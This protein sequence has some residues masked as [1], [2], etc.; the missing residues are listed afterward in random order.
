M[1]LAVVALVC[2]LA[3]PPIA[4]APVTSPRPGTTGADR[5]RAAVVG[6]DEIDEDA[7]ARAEYL[8]AIRG[9]WEGHLDGGA[10]T[11]KLARAL[12]EFAAGEGL[13]LPAREDQ[14]P[15][16]VFD[17]L[18]C[19]REV[20]LGWGGDGPRAP[21]LSP[22][23]IWRLEHA[24]V[25]RGFLHQT[26]SEV[27]TVEALDALRSFQAWTGHPAQRSEVID[28]IWLFRLGV[29][30]EESTPPPDDDAGMSR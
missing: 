7:L 21:E 26:P 14:L 22:A 19:A 30:T 25:A 11:T 18:G 5:S 8:L 10:R 17:R 13:A 4:V 23:E 6:L 9:R 24:L 2:A 3:R 12:R 16:E 28:R 1:R 20:W 27:L 29:A 15:G